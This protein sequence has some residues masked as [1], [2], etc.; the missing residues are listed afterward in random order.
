MPSF[1]K[2]KR[3]GIPEHEKIDCVVLGPENLFSVGWLYFCRF[4]S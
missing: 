3:S 2:S 4:F 1:M